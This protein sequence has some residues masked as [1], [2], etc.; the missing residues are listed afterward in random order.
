M[1]S[2]ITTTYNRRGFL[3]EAVLSV[4]K[5]DYRDKEVIV[6]DDGSTDNSIE[7]IN[8]LPVRYVRK[9][10]GGISSARNKGIAAA[11]GEYIAFLDVD[12]L[13]KKNKLSTQISQ[14]AEQGYALSYTDEI[15]IRNGERLNQKLRHKKYSGWIFERCLPLCIISPSSA[16]IRREVFDDVGLFDESLPVCEDYDMWLRVT[17]R[18]PVLFIEK[19][20]IIKRGG[21]EDQLSRRYDGMDRFRIQAI[22]KILQDGCLESEMRAKAVEE[23]RKKCLIYAKGAMR[24]NKEEEARYYLSLAEEYGGP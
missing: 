22:V 11:C 23:L 5:Q 6:V 7:E 12:D 13:W 14:M 9:D 15:W 1:V 20:L 19:P 2:V 16:V 24:R 21:H 10:N 17:A 3:K 18:Y 8:D 4:L